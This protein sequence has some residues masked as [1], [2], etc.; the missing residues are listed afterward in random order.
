MYS[1]VRSY[2]KPALKQ[3]D[4]SSFQPIPVVQSQKRNQPSGSSIYEEEA[5]TMME[6]NNNLPRSQCKFCV[7]GQVKYSEAA[8]CHHLKSYYDLMFQCSVCNRGFESWSEVL[9]HMK[10]GHK[11][12]EE[13]L[14]RKPSTAERLINA[15]C[16]MKKCKRLFLAANCKSQISTVCILSAA[17]SR[18]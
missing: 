10:D 14:I 12:E 18:L 3:I 17:I 7:K 11:T 9:R 16:K 15:N 1:R 13:G 8:Y 5:L 2:S 4:T 6:V